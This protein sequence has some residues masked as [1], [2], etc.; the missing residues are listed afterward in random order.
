M[1]NTKIKPTNFLPN[2]LKANVF[3]CFVI[4][5][6]S[7][8]IKEKSYIKHNSALYSKEQQGLLLMFSFIMYTIKK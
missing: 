6:I 7:K 3:F 1:Y 8:E 4:V 2:I 5:I